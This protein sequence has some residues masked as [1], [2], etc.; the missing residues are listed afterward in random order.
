MIVHHI[1]WV[2]ALE[3]ITEEFIVITRKTIL[4]PFVALELLYILNELPEEV[5]WHWLIWIH[6]HFASD[7][8]T[9]LK[10]IITIITDN[11]TS[12]SSSFYGT[13]WV[14]SRWELTDKFESI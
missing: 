2:V 7:V 4:F 1:Y 5:D 9:S 12:S 14:K 3:S 8:R 6:R 11:T 10:D 13:N